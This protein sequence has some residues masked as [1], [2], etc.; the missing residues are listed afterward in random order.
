MEQIK[1]VDPSRAGNDALLAADLLLLDHPGKLSDEIVQLLASLLHRGRGV[2][3]VVTEPADAVN[4]K[5][6]AQAAGSGL[7]SG[8]T[9]NGL[10]N[11]P[12]SQGRVGSGPLLPS[13]AQTAW[14]ALNASNLSLPPAGQAILTAGD[15]TFLVPLPA[16]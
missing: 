15:R 5:R 9:S 12:I 14:K 3:Y 7:A 1:R 8:S 10:P 2:L 16:R 6:L 13:V 4:L 11:C